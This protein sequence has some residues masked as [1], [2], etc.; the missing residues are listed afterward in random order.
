MDAAYV[1]VHSLLLGPLT[2]AP[3]ADRLAGSVVPSLVEVADGE[4]PFWP[5]VARRVRDAVDRLPP[6]QPIVLVAHSNA[7]PL[8]PVVGA[9]VRRPVAGYVFADARLPAVVG[10]TPTSSPARLDLLRPTATG[11]RLPP[12]TTWWDEHEVAQLLPDPSTRAAITAEQTRL[13]LSYYEQLIPVPPGWDARPCGFLLFSPAYEEMARD[14]RERGWEVDRIPGGHLH[15]V[16][17]PDTVAARI[18]A[19]TTGW[20][21]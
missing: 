6:G 15:Q 16:V 9:A 11:G 12:W 8:L 18:T 17:D 20:K 10:P 7:G 3:V 21:T 5:D 2:W 4:P 13:P 14:A 19:M 1:F